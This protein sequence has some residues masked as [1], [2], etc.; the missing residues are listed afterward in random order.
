MIELKSIPLR[1]Y[2]V[3]EQ[4]I[5]FRKTGGCTSAKLA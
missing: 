2:P 1:L 5:L 4:D 3:S